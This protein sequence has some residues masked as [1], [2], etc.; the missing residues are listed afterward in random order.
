[1]NNKVSIITTD[2]SALDDRIFYKEA[3]SLHRAGYDVTL[4]APLD[5]DGFLTDMGGKPIAKGETVLDGIRI[6]G[7]KKEQ[8]NILRLPKTWTFSLWLRLF[9]NGRLNPG[10][11]H[12]KD[13]IEKGVKVDADIYHCHEIWSLYAG[14]KI[15]QILEKRGRSP[16]L[17]YDVHEFWPAKKSGNLRE[18]IWSWIIKRFESKS[19]RL[20]DYVITVNELIKGYILCLNRSM[21]TE[22]LYNCPDFSIFKEFEKSSSEYITICHDGNLNFEC[23]LPEIL[24]AMKIIKERYNGKVKFMIVGDAFEESAKYLE[25]K[26]KEY[27]IGDIVEK[28]GW[29]PYEEVGKFISDCSIGILFSHSDIS[30]NNIFALPNKLFN[31]MRYGLPVISIDIPETHRI[32]LEFGCGIIVKE[33][34]ADGLV[35]A[36]SLL[37]EDNELRQRLGANGRKIVYEKFNWG[38]MEMRLLKVYGK[39]SSQSEYIIQIN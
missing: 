30:E 26:I 8:N 21:K 31:Y 2:H 35:N 9:A 25:S 12:L 33:R 13:M 37:I 20:V 3:R 39:L 24:Q 34:I 27:Q 38:K 11:D 16:K 22:V 14:I 23:G 10:R 5:Q 36:L 18:K 4:I 19:L 17:I 32:I 6:I 29:L 28:T 7:F 15:K 1:M